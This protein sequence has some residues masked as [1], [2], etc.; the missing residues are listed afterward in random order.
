MC[1]HVAAVLYGMGSRLDDDP[2]LLFLLRGVDPQELIAQ[3][4]ALPGETESR[5]DTLREDSLAEIF[6]IELDQENE[7]SPPAGLSPPATTANQ[8]R[9]TPPG[10]TP[11]ETTTAATVKTAPKTA[12]K[13]AEKIAKGQSTLTKAALQTPLQP[14]Q[15]SAKPKVGPKPKLFV[16]KGTSISRLR[17]KSGL[18]VQDFATR[19]GVTPASIYRWEN[20][21][22]RLN[23][24]DR[25]LLALRRLHEE[26]ELKS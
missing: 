1:K 19:L 11:T 6:G 21:R 16:P 12:P 18:T 22:G 23:L 20:S 10:K 4:M 3:G 24:Q 13:T 8:R 15:P 7:P 9:K 17:Q 14:A 5:T 26:M 2:N 25:C